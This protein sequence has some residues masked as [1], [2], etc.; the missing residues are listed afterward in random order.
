MQTRTSIV[1]ELN[2]ETAL[3]TNDSEE[4]RETEETLTEKGD[5]R[6]LKE[7]TS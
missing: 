1:F 5:S 3:F 2:S 6:F 7:D 4:R